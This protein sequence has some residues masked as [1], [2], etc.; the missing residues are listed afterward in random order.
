MPRQPTFARLL[1]E[2]RE[3]QGISMAELAAQSG[4][5]RQVIHKLEAIGCVPSWP[6]VQAVARAL[7]VPTDY[8]CAPVVSGAKTKMKGE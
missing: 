1:R 2:L 6:T 3:Q 7:D 8:F 5:S 4:L